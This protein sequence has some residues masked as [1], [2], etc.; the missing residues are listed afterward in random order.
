[1]MAKKIELQALVCCLAF[2]ST[3]IKATEE[4]D[5]AWMKGVSLQD[6]T[7]AAA[8]GD[9]SG[10]TF[11]A[12]DTAGDLGQGTPNLGQRDGYLRKYS[13]DGD[14]MWVYRLATEHLDSVSCLSHLCGVPHRHLHGGRH[15]LAPHRHARSFELLVVGG[16]DGHHRTRSALFALVAT[17]GRTC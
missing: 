8:V 14:V 12:G 15:C 16:G 6:T 9:A 10:C 4:L 3:C 1:M 13:P 5:M 2:L 11:V 17:V 7:M